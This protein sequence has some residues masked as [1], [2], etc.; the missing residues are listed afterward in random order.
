MKK[1]IAL[2]T[3]TKEEIMEQYKAGKIDLEFMCDYIEKI[4][5][6]YNLLIDEVN[7]LANKMNKVFAELTLML[8]DEDV[9]KEQALIT[10]KNILGGKYED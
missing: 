8:M 4:D 10:I 7:R 2:E 3:Y 1:L 6:T 5:H 9:S